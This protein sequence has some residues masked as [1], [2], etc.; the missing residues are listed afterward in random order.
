MNI[1]SLRNSI[2]GKISVPTDAAYENYQQSYFLTS[3]AAKS[4][5]L[6]VSPATTEDIAAAISW[7]REA[8]MG[9][10]VRGGGHGAFSSA[11]NKLVLELSLHFNEAKLR[12]QYVV[13]GGG[14]TMG[15][16][17]AAGSSTNRVVPVGAAA[18][19]GMGLALHGGI[20]WL[21]RR[22]GL[23]IDHLLEV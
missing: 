1:D 7:A 8:E 13:A 17:L 15:T 10:A 6:V 5:A 12:E 11:D 20:G 21:C 14:T 3:G 23:T 16:L 19:P 22:Y 18:G 4:P 9:V 2:Q